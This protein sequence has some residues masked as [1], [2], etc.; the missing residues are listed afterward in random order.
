M[1]KSQSVHFP[2]DEH[3]GWFQF[4]TIVKKDPYSAQWA[5]QEKMLSDNYFEIVI[6]RVVFGI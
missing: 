5:H 3:F 1:A 4:G 2:V 6:G